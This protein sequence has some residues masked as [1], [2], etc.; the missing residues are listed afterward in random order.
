MAYALTFRDKTKT[1]QD[2]DVNSAMKKIMNGLE[3][4]GI[5]LRK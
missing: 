5:E 4:L 1:L 3:G 2:E